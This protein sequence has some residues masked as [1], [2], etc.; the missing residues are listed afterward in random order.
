MT[1][2]QKTTDLRGQLLRSVSRSFYLSIR[3]LPSKLRD[4]IA[5]AYLL[6]RATDTIADT[7]ELDRAARTRH[8][9][10]LAQL[11]QGTV[12]RD[13]LGA[14][15]EAFAL[16]QQDNAEQTL[17]EQLPDCLQWLDLI[18]AEDRADIRDVLEKINEGQMLD[19]ERFG[20][21]TSVNAL[22]S[23]ADL[24]RYTYL[25]AGCVGEFWTAICLRHLPVFATRPAENMKTL[26]VEYGRGL[27]LINIVRDIGAD[28]NAGR[29]Y[30]PAE[31]L[32]SLGIEPR[33]L[34]RRA[35]LAIPVVQKW[36]ERAQ[37]GITAGI[38][39][40][41]AIQ[42]WRVRFA[43]VLPALIGARTLALFDEAG[44]GV[45]DTRV[46]ITRREVRQILFAM[47]AGLASP[48]VIRREFARLSS[49]A[50]EGGEGPH[51]GSPDGPI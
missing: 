50:S 43:T 15:V 41:C 51:R 2:R 26:A 40:A 11:I 13:A 29:C 31:E 47:F 48:S 38:E 27:Q 30:L 33:H 25:V 7:A 22:Q 8:L 46:K 35:S 6:A 17:I 44:A 49:R 3:F 39:Y 9:G 23:G 32:H 20:D 34:R 24:D 1:T 36:R 28:L 21:A 10:T 5:L 16:R 12:N 19:V 14:V 45:F 37:K 18:A 4:P 42:P